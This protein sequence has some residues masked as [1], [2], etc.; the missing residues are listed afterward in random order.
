VAPIRGEMTVA[1]LRSA[2]IQ[3]AHDVLNAALLSL[4]AVPA[5][6]RARQGARR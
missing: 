3:A 1:E 4:E 6:K 5:A 2:H